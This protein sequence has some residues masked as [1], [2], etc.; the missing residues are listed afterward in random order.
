MGTLPLDDRGLAYGDGLFETVLLRDAQPLLWREHMARLQRGAERLDVEL[1][2][3][4]TLS[5]LCAKA[6][7]GLAVLKLIV[8]RGSGGRGYRPPAVPSPRLRWQVMSFAPQPARWHEGVRVRHCQLRLGRQPALAGIKHLNRLENVLARSEWQDDAIA[9]GLLCDSHGQLV[10]ATCMNLFWLRQGRLETPS[11]SH[12]G[13]A[14]TL[15]EALLSTLDITEVEVGPEQL[16]D[17][18]AVWL[19][20]SLQG[21]WPLTQLDNAAGECLRRWSLDPRHR[22]L[23]DAGHALLGYPRQT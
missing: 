5:E 11:L 23:Q 9:E 16:L 7:P 6:P 2:A 18:E 4:D 15:R 22:L 13:V 12:C 14:G 1:P 21:V 20:N 3:Q 8:T 19:G 17:A 10:E